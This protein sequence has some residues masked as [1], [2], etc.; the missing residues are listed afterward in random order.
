MLAAMTLVGAMLISTDP[1]ANPGEGMVAWLG[2]GLFLV[3]LG[4]APRA[5]RSG[6]GGWIALIVSILAG[7][8]GL[9]LLVGTVGIAG[10]AG[11]A[12]CGLPETA[13]LSRLQ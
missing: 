4:L 12:R 1:F 7:L 2:L 11:M 5:R 8:G 6:A 9:I 10:N 3:A 13:P